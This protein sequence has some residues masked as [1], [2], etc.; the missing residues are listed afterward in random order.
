MSARH[1]DQK[2]PHQKTVDVTFEENAAIIWLNRPQRLNAVTSELVDDLLDALDSLEHSP[3]RTI[4]LAG[5]GRAFCSGHD[6]K[7]PTP[8]GDSRERLNKLQ[9]ITRKLKNSPRP[10]IAAIQGYAIG[11][12]AEFALGCDLIV[13][14]E[15][16]V[17]AFPEVR[18][19]L[20]V[21]GAA[22]RLLPLLVGPYKAKE[23]LLLGEP[24][25]APAAERLGLV[26]AVVPT[27]TSL[28]KAISWA[29]KL[30]EKPESSTTLA[31]RALD[32][33]LD[34]SIENAL[35][36]EI[37]HALRTENSPEVRASMKNFRDTNFR[38][39]S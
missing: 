1:Q 16:A 37:E 11:A 10:I 32:A 15:N 6:L 22:S 9:E 7:E 28:K 39:R 18:L 24:L 34:G 5:R 2:H 12:G 27:G 31:K 4:I 8:P 19:G 23:L 33:G 25:T 21:T 29:N 20:S 13:A 3:A 38:D 14:E 36:L 17:F 35:E 26:N 30:A